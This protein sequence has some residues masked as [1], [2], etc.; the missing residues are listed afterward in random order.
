M[1]SWDVLQEDGAI[2]WHRALF[3]KEENAS[4]SARVDA[5]EPTSDEG[6][7]ELTPT[8]VPNKKIHI[9]SDPKLEL[10]LAANPNTPVSA[11][12]VLN[13]RVRPRRSAL[14]PQA[15]A[16]FESKNE[17]CQRYVELKR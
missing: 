3:D 1:A 4:G 2:C 16:P 13:G 15:R 12:V 7:I 10:Q 8:A 6:S 17:P 11:S 5:S 9:L 14:L